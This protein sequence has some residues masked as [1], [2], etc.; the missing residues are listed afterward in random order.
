MK[1]IAINASEDVAGYTITEPTHIKGYDWTS[2]ITPDTTTGI[3]VQTSAHL[4]LSNLEIV[5]GIKGVYAPRVYTGGVNVTPSIILENVWIHG[6]SHYG[7]ETTGPLRI[8]H[9]FIEYCGNNPHAGHCVHAGGEVNIHNSIIRHGSAYSLYLY[10]GNAEGAANITGYVTD[11]AIYGSEKCLY[12]NELGF[13]KQAGALV[14][15]VGN[16]IFKT[17]IPADFIVDGMCG[18]SIGNSARFVNRGKGL[19]WPTEEITVGCFDYDAART[20]AWATNDQDPIWYAGYMY[21][22][23]ESSPIYPIFPDE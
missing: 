17:V 18:N 8:H 19:F 20:E 3:C 1:S 7:V 15:V 4:K 6:C 21:A 9:G 23:A 2:T 11:N 13:Y 14:K 12:T 10:N 5:G 16:T 22:S